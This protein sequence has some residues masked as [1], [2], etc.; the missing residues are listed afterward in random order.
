[1]VQTST[2]S[3]LADIPDEELVGLFL[4][5]KEK[6]YFEAIYERYERRV[7]GRCVVILKDAE[8]AQDVMQ[9]IFVKVY[10]KLDGFRGDAKFSTWIHRVTTN[11]CLNWIQKKSRSAEVILDEEI[12]ELVMHTTEDPLHQLLE[13]SKNVLI[14]Q[15]LEQ[16]DRNDTV[17]I[18][19]KY[20]DGESMAEIAEKFG[21]TEGAAKVRLFRARKKFMEIFERLDGGEPP[22]SEKREVSSEKREEIEAYISPTTRMQYGIG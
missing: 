5:A 14:R 12:E 17:M 21:I 13:S 10:F 18:L 8:E 20:A 9:E 7:Y 2:Q 15:T 6:H 16:M 11:T 3:D 1:M 19:M 4:R 22:K